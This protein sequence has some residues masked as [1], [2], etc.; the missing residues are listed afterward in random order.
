VLSV[1]IAIAAWAAAALALSAD[2]SVVETPWGEVIDAVIG[3]VQDVSDEYAAEAHAAWEKMV[4]K[5]AVED[6]NV[7]ATVTLIVTDNWLEYTVRYV[8][9]SKKRRSTK[10]LLNNR[11]LDEF[12]ATKGKVSIASATFH[13][14]ETPTF[15]VRLEK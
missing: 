13:L 10:D 1:L 12:D 4:S 8:V 15:S 14:V 7:D 3:V 5:Y 2:P 11:I 9:D 6:A